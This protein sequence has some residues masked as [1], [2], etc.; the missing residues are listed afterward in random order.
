MRSVIAM[1]AV[2][3]ATGLALAACSG[4]P[5]G[6]D[7]PA[8]SGISYVA[9][10]VGSTIFKAGARPA[11]P[12]ISGTTLTGARLSLTA[13]RGKVVVLN[14]WGSWC[15]PCRSEGATLA[16]LSRQYQPEGAQFIGIDIRDSA[17]NAEAFERNVG[18]GYPSLNDQGDAI[19]LAFRDTV[20]PEGIPTTLVIDRTGHIA[21]RIIGQASYSVL[22][23]MVSQLTATQS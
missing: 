16:A 12:R 2:A 8:S 22:N 20:P 6:Q 11:A 5:I 19:A 17:V 3:V 9:G 15:G 21:G 13:Y 4:G 7:N 10:S 1:T 14:F 18:I 23:G